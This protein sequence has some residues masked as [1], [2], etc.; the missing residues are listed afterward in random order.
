M[1][2][3]Y[4]IPS[5]IGNPAWSCSSPQLDSSTQGFGELESSGGVELSQCDAIKWSRYNPLQAA[6]AAFAS[7]GRG[8][9]VFEYIIRYSPRRRAS[10]CLAEGFSPTASPVYRM[11]CSKTISP[12]ASPAY[13]INF[14]KTISRRAD[15]VDVAVTVHTWGNSRPA[16]EGVSPPSRLCGQDARAPRRTLNTYERGTSREVPRPTLVER[17]GFEPL[18]SCLQ[19]RRSPN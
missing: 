11:N 8:L 14:S 6:Q 17:R 12:T 3:E 1:G 10:P 5:G 2:F 4:I 7:P 16:S 18:T 13:R 19:S 15:D 9:M